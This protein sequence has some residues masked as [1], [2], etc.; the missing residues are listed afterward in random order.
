[1]AARAHDVAALALRGRS[2]CLNFADSLWRL[3]HGE[4]VPLKLLLIKNR[5]FRR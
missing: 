3:G 5:N 4:T 2:A 1:M